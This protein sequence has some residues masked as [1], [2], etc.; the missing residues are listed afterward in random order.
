[1]AV[2]RIMIVEDQGIVALSLKKMLH[3]LGYEVPV[4]VLYPDY[5]DE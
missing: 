1:M 4:K 2:A 3:D 5:Y